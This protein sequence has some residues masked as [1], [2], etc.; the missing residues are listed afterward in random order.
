M[1]AL[2][3]GGSMAAIYGADSPGGYPL[4]A[5][6]IP[7]WRTYG[8]I[9]PFEPSRPW[10]LSDFD[11]VKF[12]PYN[13][14]DYEKV[15]TSFLAGTYE[16]EVEETLFDVAAQ[17]EFLEKVKD[18]AEEFEKNQS[19]AL[20]ECRQQEEKLFAAWKAEEDSKK[21]LLQKRGES[22]FDFENN[23]N[24]VVIRAN[25][26]GSVWKIAAD[27]GQ[28]I[29]EGHTVVILEAMK[30]E[31]NVKCDENFKVMTI[32]KNPGEQV[33]PGDPLVVGEKA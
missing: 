28:V 11:F 1:G 9:P 25:L 32:L 10:L 24:A 33:L 12:I 5:R 21:H 17:A 26:P 22:C 2:G 14:E 6:T 13:Q 30:S 20:E 29:K 15:L 4:M 19:K 8:D 31:I 23:P 27:E 3:L 16:F 18:E 7:G